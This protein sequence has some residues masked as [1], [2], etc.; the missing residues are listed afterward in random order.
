MLGRETLGVMELHRFGLNNTSTPV[1]TYPALYSC[2]STIGYMYYEKTVR[3]AKSHR[4]GIPKRT[5]GSGPDT[6]HDQKSTLGDVGRGSS[7]C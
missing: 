4:R 1:G 5:V 3:L 7:I 6:G 2:L